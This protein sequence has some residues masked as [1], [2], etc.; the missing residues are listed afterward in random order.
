[1]GMSCA[2]TDPNFK[3]SDEESTAVIHKAIDLGVTLLDTSDVYGP[4]TNEVLVGRLLTGTFQS[5]GPHIY[6]HAFSLCLAVWPCLSRK[7]VPGHLSLPV[8]TAT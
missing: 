6:A 3:G 8:R 2:Y 5:D 1:M 4:F 7:A